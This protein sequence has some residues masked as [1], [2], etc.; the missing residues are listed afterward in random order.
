MA[1]GKTMTVKAHP[2][3]NLAIVN[4]GDTVSVRISEARTFTGGKGSD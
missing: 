4:P 3:T 1:D 2:Y